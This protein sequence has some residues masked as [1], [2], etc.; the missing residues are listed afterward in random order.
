MSLSP[1]R[2]FSPAYCFALIVAVLVASGGCQKQ[3]L[4]PRQ[5]IAFSHKIHAGQYQ[6]S[7]QYCHSG[8]RRGKAAMIPSVQTCIG[9]H[10]LVAATKPEVQKIRRAWEEKQTI[11]WTRV[12]VLPDFVY[13]N[14]QPHILK[15]IPCQQCHGEIQTMS[16][17]APPF[18][19]ANMA[20]CVECHRENKASIDCWTCHR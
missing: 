3:E 17:V 1:I 5:P 12:N 7:C 18:T 14:H 9:C 20:Y 15:S 6:M 4:K 16:E 2:V 19:L 13:F 8:A 11:R 10:Q